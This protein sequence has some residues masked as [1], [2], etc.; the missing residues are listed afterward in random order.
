DALKDSV[1]KKV[2]GST[3]F[4]TDGT[5][6]DGHALVSSDSACIDIARSSGDPRGLANDLASFEYYAFAL[7][8]V[9][10][11]TTS[12]QAPASMSIQ[13]IQNIFNCTWDHWDQVPGGGVGQIQRFMPDASSGTGDTF[14]RKVLAGDNPYNHSSLTCPTVINMEENHGDKFTL[15]TSVTGSFG[16][17]VDQAVFPYSDGKWTYQANNN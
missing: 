11:A 8:I 5:N 3:S 15:S 7:D 17:Y 16:A 6:A 12:F 2:A 10:P 9:T 14:I 4:P 1:N 13:T